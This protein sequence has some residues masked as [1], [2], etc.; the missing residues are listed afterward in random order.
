MRG[1]DV[2]LPHG[3]F[4]RTLHTVFVSCWRVANRLR[5]LVSWT[6]FVISTETPFWRTDGNDVAKNTLTLG[7]M[8]CWTELD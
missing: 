8:G 6:I 2:T 3:P 4:S 5:R 7:I 1:N